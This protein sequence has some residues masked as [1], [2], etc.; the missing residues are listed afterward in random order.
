M[1]PVYL[2]GLA[3]ACGG[4][5]HAPTPSPAA[6]PPSAAAT[7]PLHAAR[8]NGTTL[9]YRLVGDS[10]TPVVFVHGS[11]GNL[12]DWDNQ[13]AAFARTHRVLVYSRRYHPPNP[14]QI[15]DQTYSPMLHAD[16]L[17]ALL[18]ALQLAPAHV[19]GSSYGAY[20]ALVLA[21]EHPEL[22]RSVV[23][24]EPPIMPLLTGTEEGD[25]IRRAFF[26]NTLDP[27]RAAF[28][29]GDSVAA[30]R[31]YVD[32]VRGTRSFDNLPPEARA[33][34]VAHSFEMRREM[35]ANR[36]QYM[37]PLPCGELGRIHTPVLLLS[38][39]RSTRLFHVITAE[40]ARCLRSDTTATIPG[41]THAMHQT[42]P[43]YYNQIVLRYLAT[44]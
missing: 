23:L 41:A 28:T 43:A 27:A 40:L 18:L 24:G 30:L 14:L 20:T 15:D 38:A 32:G 35:L 17:A 44:H 42:N 4:G 19:V 25:A 10:G 1:R 26:A 3:A 13:V 9:A 21:R 29:R 7:A 11:L 8:V 36:E 2:L 39:E 6:A 16:D 37:P 34:I 31:L 5:G 12:R 22:V 33:R